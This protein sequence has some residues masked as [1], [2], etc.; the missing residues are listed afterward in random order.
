MIAFVL[1]A[2]PSECTKSD[3][4]ISGKDIEE[5]RSQTLAQRIKDISKSTHGKSL[6]EK[7]QR[8]LSLKLFKA[9]GDP[10]PKSFFDSRRHQA[11]RWDIGFGKRSQKQLDA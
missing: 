5:T 8:K 7:L 6:F 4:H 1:F 10:E 9:S 2:L 11:A 3:K